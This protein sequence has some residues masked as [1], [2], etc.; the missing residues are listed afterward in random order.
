M[1]SRVVTMKRR[2]DKIRPGNRASPMKNRDQSD[3]ARWISL[4][5]S[6]ICFD[7][8]PD[9][10]S[11]QSIDFK[12]VENCFNAV[13]MFSPMSA[14]PP[15]T[16]LAGNQSAI[17]ANLQRFVSPNTA[18]VASALSLLSRLPYCQPHH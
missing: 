9:T 10:T 15:I 1:L 13:Q 14:V 11:L 7:C 2:R 18:N 12:P 6:K 17:T 4:E 16:M 8:Q 3:Q 5:D